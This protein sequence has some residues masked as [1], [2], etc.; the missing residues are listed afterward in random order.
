MLGQ[1]RLGRGAQGRWIG[2]VYKGRWCPCGGL[3]GNLFL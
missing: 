2:L 1:H 3:D